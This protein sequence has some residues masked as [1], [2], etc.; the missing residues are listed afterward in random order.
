[1]AAGGIVSDAVTHCKGS[2][3]DT[4]KGLYDDAFYQHQVSG[5]YRSAQVYAG[6][7]AT[8]F[9]PKSVVDFGCGRGTSA[10]PRLQ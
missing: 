9:T 8:F 7:I 2:I 1:M 3:V 5:S 6:L 4:L 10:S